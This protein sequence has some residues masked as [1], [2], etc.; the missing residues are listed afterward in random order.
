LAKAATSRA[1]S[2]FF[3]SS[4]LWIASEAFYSNADDLK[5]MAERMR[6]DAP[7]R[8]EEEIAALLAA[9]VKETKA[10]TNPRRKA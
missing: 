8:N 10:L 4:P 2:T 6:R 9:V 7:W 5:A 1:I 3:A